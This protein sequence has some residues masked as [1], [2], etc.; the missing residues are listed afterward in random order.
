MPTRLLP[1]DSAGPAARRPSAAV[2][3]IALPLVAS[4]FWPPAA[5]L[6]PAISRVTVT[7]AAV[8]LQTYEV[9][10]ADTSLNPPAAQLEPADSVVTVTLCPG[11]PLQT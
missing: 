7:V 2:L 11:A 1:S 4:I 10:L 5:Q 6:A 9:P 8:P 3:A